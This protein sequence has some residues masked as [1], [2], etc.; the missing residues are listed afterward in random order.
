MCAIDAL[1]IAPM[2][3]LPVEVVS[4]DSISGDAIRVQLSLDLSATWRPEGAAVL[5]GSASC[6]GPSFRGCCD[7]LN[8]FETP[9]NAERYLLELVAASLWCPVQQLPRCRAARRC[10]GRSTSRCGRRPRL[11]ARIRCGRV[12]R[13]AGR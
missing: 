11:R 4:H 5:A 8:F 1:A 13:H 9:A 10:R 3:D 6:D 2:P 12:A 7:V